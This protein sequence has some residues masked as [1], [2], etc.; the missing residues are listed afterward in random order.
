MW[1][2]CVI[3]DKVTITNLI[4]Q[5]NLFINSQKMSTR[6]STI[7]SE[8]HLIFIWVEMKF[9]DHVGILDHQLE[10]SWMQE[11]SKIMVNFK[12]IGGIKWN[13]LFLK[14]DLLYSGEMMLKT[15]KL[16]IMISF[17]SGELKPKFQK[18]LFL[19]YTVLGNTTSR[20]ILSTSDYL[21]INKG[22]GN[23]WFNSSAGSYITW[24]QIYQGFEIFPQGVDK[25]KILGA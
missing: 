5:N 6:K 16:P 21:Y 10:H 14:T 24:K 15:L 13:R 22:I 1:L 7:Y 9:L 23:I 19:F 25:S 4:F 8:T 3:K 11:V 18:V 20:V 12:C 2:Y 17:I